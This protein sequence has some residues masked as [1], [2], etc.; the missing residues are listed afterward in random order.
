MPKQ[1]T[2]LRYW[3]QSKCMRYPRLYMWCVDLFSPVYTTRKIKLIEKRIL[4]HHPE[5]NIIVN[6]GAGVSSYRK[7]IINCDICPDKVNVSLACD[8]LMIPIKSNSVDLIINIALLE[9]VK[10]PKLV[11]EEM[12]RILKDKGE[13]WCFVPFMQPYHAAPSDYYRWTHNGVK[14]LFSE[15][16]YAKIYVGNGPTSSMLWVMQEWLAILFSFGNRNFKE[17]LFFVFMIISFPF[18]Y[19]DAIL[20]YYPSAEN[21]VSG[22][23]I[24]A[25]KKDQ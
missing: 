20:T 6:L 15:F 25:K 23:Y 22:Y 14:R 19:L 4:E 17:C 13:I 16:P 11:I 9:H 10:E 7:D 24:H 21:L 8:A 2:S 18:K 1:T 12:F 5:G 3:L